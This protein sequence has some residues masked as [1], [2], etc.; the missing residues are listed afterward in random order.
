MKKYFVLLFAIVLFTAC[1]KDDVVTTPKADKTIMAYFVADNSL[2]NDLLDNIVDMYQGLEQMK[3]SASLLIYWD[4]SSKGPL[5]HPC[6]LY[7]MSDGKGRV[8]RSSGLTTSVDILAV[9]EVLKEYPSQLSTDK[10]IMAKVLQ[11]MVALCPSKQY[12]LI[13]GSHGSGW[14][15]YITGKNSRS[16]GQDGGSYSESTISMQDMAEAI[17]STGVIYDF[18]LF[19]ACMMGCAEVYY[20]FRNVAKYM[21]ASVINVPAPGFPYEQMLPYLY[22]NGEAD[23]RK[24]CEVFIDRYKS[25]TDTR[26]KFGTMSLV[27]CSEMQKLAEL[28]KRQIATHKDELATYSPLSLQYYGERGSSFTYYSFDAKQFI[29]QLNGGEAPTD[30]VAQLN[31]TVLYTDFVKDNFF[32]IDGD[33]YCGMGMYIPVTSKNY[34][35]EYFKTLSWF[36]AAGWNETIWAN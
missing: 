23:Y 13:A 24:A 17:Q 12:G 15:K 28:M 31:K 7:Y 20:D 6:I 26:I 4:G 9:A 16:F 8:N 35:N 11:D 2:E 14:L 33:H 21:I 5:S 18:F 25:E 1:E 29:E 30:F 19:D 3:D 36:S 22:G 34:W 27:D 32:N 10:A